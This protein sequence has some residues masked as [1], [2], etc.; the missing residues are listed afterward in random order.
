[1]RLRGNLDSYLYAD[2]Y[3][4]IPSGAIKS[5]LLKNKF[6]F[7]YTSFQFLLVRLRGNRKI[8]KASTPITISIPSGAIK[9]CVTH[10]TICIS[11]AISIPSGAIKSYKSTITAFAK[12]RFQFLLVRLREQIAASICII[13]YVY[14]NSFWCD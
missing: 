7:Y 4:S 1:M 2:I 6:K 11:I 3:I 10:S 12:A 13:A 8:P 9:R 14:F 5:F